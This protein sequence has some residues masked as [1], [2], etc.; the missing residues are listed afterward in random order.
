MKYFIF[1]C[2][3]LFPP[4]LFS[5]EQVSSNMEQELENIAAAE[6]A[7]TTDDN[8]WQQVEYL[9]KNP[10]NLNLAGE[11]E[12]KELQLLTPLQIEN[13]IT[14]RTL[15]GK[16]IS[17]YELQAVPGWDLSII[18]KLLPY[19]SVSN[20]VSVKEDFFKRL[21]NGNHFFMARFSAVPEKAKGYRINDTALSSYAGDPLRMM[22]R[23]KYQYKNLLQYGIT[24]AKDAGEMF[25]AKKG[26]DFY[27]LHFFLRNT[28]I[29]K[30][31]ALGDY[32]VN[33][34]Q[35][36]IQWQGLAFGK[37]GEITAGKRQS[38]ILKPY[39]STGSYLFHRGGAFTVE[40]KWLQATAFASFRNQ[41]AALSS[42]N[43]DYVATAI[44]T[45][46]Y[47]RTA[48]EIADKGALKQLAYGTNITGKYKKMQIGFNM[49][50]YQFDKSI[51]KE[52]K[53]YNLY[54]LSG[55]NWS[56]YSME[57]GFTIKNMHFFGETAVDKKNN[58]ATINGV[59]ISADT[60]ANLSVIYRNISKSYQS[61]YGNAFTVNTAPVNEQ[62]LFAAV[63]L[64]PDN[65]WKID[66][67]AD[68]YR[69]PWLKYRVDAPSQGKDY[70]IQLTYK[71][72]KL[73]DINTRYRSQ[74]K[75]INN[76]ADNN[77][78]NEVIPFSNRSWRTQINYQ[79]SKVF[80]IRQR[81]EL[82]WFNNERADPEKGFLSFFDVFCKPLFKPFNTNI[83][84]Q[85]FES[86]SYNSRLYAFENDVLY[87]YSV[88]A[89][90]DK[91]W[92]YY[93]NIRWNI[94][95][96]LSVWVKWAQSIYPDKSSIGSGL[97]EIQGKK[98]SEARILL[99]AEF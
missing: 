54:A 31:I 49:V 25:T 9:K 19:I 37:G 83:R 62:G 71:P 11:L 77:P 26:F 43:D 30:S 1:I 45:S 32:T 8:W 15:L 61:L 76:N 7:E 60:K 74:Y 24:T 79:V 42:V 89:F 82:L 34:G 18:Q 33:M 36:L 96:I 50:Q 29:F 55:K 12:L 91:G 3:F 63:S 21:S 92:R 59:I 51:Q 20:A 73:T 52:N 80:S 56:N 44:H 10:I 53:P 90:Y 93:M 95:S 66:V 86:N 48:S 23:Y 46:G 22:F 16:L 4:C 28:G 99:Y 41:D 13:F 84:I 68:L 47:H 58:A 81:V 67:Y 5:Q 17:L 27:S 85:Y 2:S 14:Y 78:V 6:D 72:S 94:N 87:Y 65:I 70:F 64:K 98:R 38:A 97:D 75:P 39:N 57:Y 40:K 35:G 88:P 69:F